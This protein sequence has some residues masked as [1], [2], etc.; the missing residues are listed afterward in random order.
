MVLPGDDWKSVTVP[1]D[2]GAPK[3]AAASASPAKETAKV[4]HHPT[5]LM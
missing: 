2:A 1:A 4:D 3:Q 5:D